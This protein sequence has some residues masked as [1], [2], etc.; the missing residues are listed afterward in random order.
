M[1]NQC[2]I[3]VLELQG[4]TL[5]CKVMEYCARGTLERFLYLKTGARS[6]LK[7]DSAML[8]MAHM[9]SA[10]NYLDEQHVLHRFV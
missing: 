8:L 1:T 10:L 2:C 4:D 5:Y 3:Q 6:C 9:N 7:N